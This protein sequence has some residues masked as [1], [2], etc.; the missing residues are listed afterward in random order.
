MVHNP[1]PFVSMPI[2]LEIVC[3]ID[4]VTMSYDASAE[5]YFE[6][7]AKAGT[8]LI[9]VPKLECTQQ[10]CCLDMTWELFEEREAA[11]APSGTLQPNSQL[12]VVENGSSLDVAV[13]TD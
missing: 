6:V 3:G 11:G 12:S 10:A 5:T 1:D 13:P 2:T 8:T 4:A 7:Y 9:Q